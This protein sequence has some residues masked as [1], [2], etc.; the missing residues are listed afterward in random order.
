MSPAKQPVFEPS[1]M[2]DTGNYPYNNDFCY[3][4]MGDEDDF[5]DSYCDPSDLCN[6]DDDFFMEGIE[7]DPSSC[8]GVWE[9]IENVFPDGGLS[10]HSVLYTNGTSLRSQ[11]HGES[12][13]NEQ[14]LKQS[15]RKITKLDTKKIKKA[16][17]MKLEV[18][19]H[20]APKVNC[21]KEM[22]S[23]KLVCSGKVKLDA[24]K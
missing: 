10:S 11:D 23:N 20:K 8:Y 12:H 21:P 24:P 19:E 13:T 6:Y 1:P 15:A 18:V 5:D 17:S 9:D 16:Y 2:V 3:Y 7:V 22:C 4:G 14:K